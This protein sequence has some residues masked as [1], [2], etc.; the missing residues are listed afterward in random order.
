MTQ[1]AEPY[2]NLRSMIL[3]ANPKD[4]GIEPSETV[5]NVWGVLMEFQVSGT[6]VTLV[7]LADG[8][9]SMY[10]GNGGGIIGAGQH[11]EVAMVSRS[12]VA[13]AES[14][15]SQAEPTTEFPL[16]LPARVRFYFLTFSGIRTTER[17]Q[18]RLIRQDDSFSSLFYASNEV[19]TQIRL[20][21]PSRK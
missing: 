1:P 21:T 16:P 15:Y 7:S 17:D 19:I 6:V 3:S 20:H 11:D 14:F 18:D 4:I 13:L 5:R 2:I 8:T 10:F 12:F 9:T